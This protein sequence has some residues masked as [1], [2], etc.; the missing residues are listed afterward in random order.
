M[1]YEVVQV[2]AYSGHRGMERPLAFVWRGRRYG[3]AEVVDRWYEGGM[4][5]RDV[6]LDYFKVRV[7]DGAEFILRYNALFDAWAVRVKPEAAP[8]EEAPPEDHP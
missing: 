8:P 2:E 1:P 6:K 4:R 5:P 7:E 3:V